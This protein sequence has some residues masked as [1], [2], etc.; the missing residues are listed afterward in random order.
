TAGTPAG[1]LPPDSDGGSCSSC[2]SNTQT[3]GNSGVFGGTGGTI[4]GFSFTFSG[5]TMPS[6]TSYAINLLKNGSSY[7]GAKCTIN[8]GQS[9]CSV[10]SLNVSSN[11]TD[12]WS[13]SYTKTGSGSPN[14]TGR[15][16]HLT[17]S[18]NAAI[19]P[20]AASISQLSTPHIVIG[21]AS[22]TSG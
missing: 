7:G 3:L 14:A 22:A 5:T 17:G 6:G 8:T 2:S 4:T 16:A 10:G 19:P 1:V 13:I 15:V 11:G 18:G 21:T 9:T 12:V 20:G